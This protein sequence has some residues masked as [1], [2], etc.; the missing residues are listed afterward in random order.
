MSNH[1]LKCSEIFVETY[2]KDNKTIIKDTFFT[3]PFKITSP[4]YDDEKNVMKLCIMNISPGMLQG[5]V[6]TQHFKLN[7]GSKVYMFSQS[8]SK[9]FSMESDGIA[10][11][12][13][14]VNLKHNSSLEYFPLPTI[15]YKDSSYKGISEFYMEGD[16]HLIYREILSCGRYKMGENFSYKHFSSLV[17]VYYEN[18]LLLMDN[19][20]LVPVL[21]DIH[22]YGFY[23]GYSHSANVFVISSKV[24]SIYRDSLNEL[25]SSYENVSFGIS[26]SSNK[27]IIIRILANNSDILCKLTDEIRNRTPW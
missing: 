10:E 27:S 12:R 13:L 20:T 26:L 9:I 15:P 23:E 22:G 11:Q 25:L 14:K 1:Y 24:S 3:S 8:F 4:F 17:K 5:D 7:E 2:V 19:T 6:Y 21:Q 16:S 18:R